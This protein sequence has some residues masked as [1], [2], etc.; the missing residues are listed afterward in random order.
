M[1]SSGNDDD[2]GV[3]GRGKYAKMSAPNG[4]NVRRARA[5]SGV[6]SDARTAKLKPSTHR[7][8]RRMETL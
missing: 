5:V 6:K 4:K 3:G 1:T 8:N 2:A 7:S